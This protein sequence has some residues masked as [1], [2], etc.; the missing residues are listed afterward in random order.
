MH[1][2][3]KAIKHAIKQVIQRMIPFILMY[4]WFKYTFIDLYI[5]KAKSICLQYYI[6]LQH[7]MPFFIHYNSI[8]MHQ[9]QSCLRTNRCI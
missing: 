8:T 6:C 7:Y 5:G 9:H 1:D 4:T 3:S 2:L